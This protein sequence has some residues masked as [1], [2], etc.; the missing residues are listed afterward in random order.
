MKDERMDL[1]NQF[2]ACRFKRSD[3]LWYDC[4][5]LTKVRMH[6][7]TNARRSIYLLPTTTQTDTHT[8]THTQPAVMDNNVLAG[9]C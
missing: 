3:S 7:C 9:A 8:H 6:E 5:H 1:C 4:G 2:T